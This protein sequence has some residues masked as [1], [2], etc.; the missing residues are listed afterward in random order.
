MFV[1]WI[2]SEVYPCLYKVHH[3][4]LIFHS[5]SLLFMIASENRLRINDQHPYF[6]E[7]CSPISSIFSTSWIAEKSTSE[8]GDLL[9]SAYKSLREKE[10][11]E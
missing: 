9:K 3:Q 8:L 5:F 1:V 4:T 7:P 2:N 6:E 11:G 10:R